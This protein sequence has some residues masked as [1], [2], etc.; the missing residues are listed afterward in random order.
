MK[1]LFPENKFSPFPLGKIEIGLPFLITLLFASHPIHTEAVA[2]IKGRDDILNF[3]FLELSLLFI[4]KF[5]DE[6]V[7]K[8]LWLSTVFFFLSLL[9]KEMAVTFLAIIPL[10]VFFFREIAIKKIAVFF[11]SFVAAF[12]VYM[13]IRSSVL[14]TVTFAE[15]MKVVNNTLAAATNE[16]DRIA[17]AILIL[18]KYILL[19]FFP[20]PLS[21]D[22]SFNQIPIVSFADIKVIITL[23]VFASL[24]TFAVINFKKKN[25]FVYCILFFSISM[26]VVSN[27][28]IMIGSTLGERF[29]FAPSIAFC[30][31]IPFL[32][33]RFGKNIFLAVI[34]IV[35][36]LFSFKTFMRNKD[37]KDSFSLFA[38]GVEATPNSSRAESALGFSYRKMGEK[39]TDPSKRIA[40]FQKSVAYY[41]KAIEILPDNTEALYDAGVSYYGMGDKENALKF[42]KQTLKISPEYTN[43]AN[44]A[45][46]IY[47]ERKDYENAKNY[48]L[49]AIKY[50][51]NNADALGYLGATNHNLGN[52]REAIEYYRKYLQINPANQNVQANLAKAEQVR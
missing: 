37:W 25:I 26:S 28:F 19:L 22:Y 20:H 14:D 48:F 51:P 17:T 33:N 44:N 34:V 52:M 32:L 45:G 3:I 23:I 12:G 27:I 49:Q 42:Y 16:S 38:S 50:D 7:K 36:T 31:A 6:K 2:N 30:I 13:L 11:V 43:A 39:E 8:Y 15:K 46:V 40:L 29:L 24:G 18:G 35:V 41:K 4:L 1:K 9:C 10:T 5:V 47:F 21:W